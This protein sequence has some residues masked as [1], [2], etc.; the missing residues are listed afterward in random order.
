LVNVLFF[1][2]LLVWSFISGEYGLILTA[3]RAVSL[4]D[5][6]YS[7]SARSIKT[8]LK[9][10]SIFFKMNIPR[11]VTGDPGCR[12]GQYFIAYGFSEMI[13]VHSAVVRLVDKERQADGR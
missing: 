11:Q 12:N 5:H 7:P 8:L 2:I 13:T 4:F 6:E 3:F 1:V 10:C 9:Y